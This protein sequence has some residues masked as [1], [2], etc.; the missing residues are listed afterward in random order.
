MAFA[1]FRR[2]VHGKGSLAFLARYHVVSVHQRP[3]EMVL[4][5]SESSV[6][7]FS[8]SIGDHQGSSHQGRVPFYDEIQD[9][10][11]KTFICALH[12]RITTAIKHTL[13]LHPHYL[14]RPCAESQTH[15][16]TQPTPPTMPPPVFTESTTT[17]LPPLH[18]IL[19]I[20][21]GP[22]GLAVAARLREHTPS[23][24]YT[25][26]E[27]RRFHWLRKHAGASSVKDRRTGRV[28]T[29]TTL[30]SH[31]G[32]RDLLVLDAEGK[33]WMTRWHALFAVFR[34][35]H[36][37]SPMFFH[38]CPSDRDSL[39]AFAHE[40]GRTSELE[41]IAG[42]VGKE[43]SKHKQKKRRRELCGKCGNKGGQAMAPCTVDERDRKDY[44]TP[45]TKMF[46]DFVEGVVGKY[47]LAEE[48]VVREE[49]V[50]DVR[51]GS[52]P[53]FE[54]KGGGER[55]FAVKSAGGNVHYAKAVVLAVGAGNAPSIPELF[56][57]IGMGHEAAC[58]ALTL[59]GEGG[60]PKVLKAKV[61]AGKRT[62]VLVVGGGLTS[63]QIGDLVLRQ[64]V[65]RVWH[66]MRGTMKGLF[67]G[68]LV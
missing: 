15:S 30:N 62:E 39:L 48:G 53:M 66:L 12:I 44:F 31:P 63:A 40:T 34:I 10:K 56:G 57:G 27:H 3:D 38:P 21:A 23:A 14:T 32:E 52:V 8:G 37:R 59:R 65:S 6:Y 49:R 11:I 1:A 24:L 60:L 25:D 50:E 4:G 9:W 46:A 17:T 58:H 67:C 16:F 41:E 28:R 51:Y 47:G 18:D 45:S 54:A 2:I 36:L 68:L 35:Q 19:I 43:L 20:G 42:C 29:A 13:T 64:G 26:E 61:A 7:K 55:V 33:D 5:T 22:S